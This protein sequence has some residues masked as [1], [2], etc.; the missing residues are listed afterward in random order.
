MPGHMLAAECPCGFG[1]S[2]LPGV[3]E[4][5]WMAHKVIAYDPDTGRLVTLP[6]KEAARRRLRVFDDP[7]LNPGGGP[8]GPE[9]SA[10]VLCPKCGSRELRFRLEGFWD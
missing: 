4:I 10:A 6:E 2:V 8:F 5:R 3:S 7:F 1:G 9:E